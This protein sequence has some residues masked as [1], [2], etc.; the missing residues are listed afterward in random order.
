MSKQINIR[1]YARRLQIAVKCAFQNFR[2][3]HDSF[4]RCT[5]KLYISETFPSQI[6]RSWQFF[7]MCAYVLPPVMPLCR[8]DAAHFFFFDLRETQWRSSRHLRLGKQRIPNLASV[9]E[10]P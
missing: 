10:W 2:F 9:N 5:H 8:M 4:V 1:G 6:E 3:L 7:D